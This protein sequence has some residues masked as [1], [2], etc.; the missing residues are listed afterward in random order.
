MTTTAK[1]K[2]KVEITET[3]SGD[4]DFHAKG[5]ELTDYLALLSGVFVQL[6]NDNQVPAYPLINGM[7]KEELSE[8]D[9]DNALITKRDLAILTAY[10]GYLFGKF[11]DFHGYAEEILGQPFFTHQFGK[12]GIFEKLHERSK[13]DFLELHERLIRE[14]EGKD[15]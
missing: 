6:C 15:D 9:F 3:D 1:N 14:S 5:G 13:E 11:Q 7:F 8:Y 12:K 10:T 4:Y 2:L